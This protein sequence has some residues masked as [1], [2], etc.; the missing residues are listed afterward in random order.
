[1]NAIKLDGKARSRGKVTT[2]QLMG[3]D[4]SWLTVRDLVISERSSG[5]KATLAFRGDGSHYV[6]VTARGEVN[7]IRL[8]DNALL[9]MKEQID[10]YFERKQATS[11]G[12]LDSKNLN[13]LAAGD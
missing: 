5:D 10:G 2:L 3:A 9:A 6:S 13:A 11:E 4:M 7:G 1:M 12:W 8:D